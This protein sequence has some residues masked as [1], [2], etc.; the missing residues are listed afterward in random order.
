VLGSG[1]EETLRGPNGPKKDSWVWVVD[2]IDGTTNFASGLTLS[3][4]SIC[5]ALNGQ[6]AVAVVYDPFMDEMFS[7]VEGQGAT[8]NGERLSVARAPSTFFATASTEESAA[9]LGEAVVF[10]GSPPALNSMGPSLRGIAALMPKVRTVRLVGSAALMLAWVAAGRAQAYF[11]ADLNS[12]D[13]AAGALLIQEAGGAVCDLETLEPYTLRTRRILAH[14]G[15]GRLVAALHRELKAANA[16]RLDDDADNNSDNGAEDEHGR[17]DDGG[18]EGRTDYKSVL[19][20]AEIEEREDMGRA[21][22][23]DNAAAALANKKEDPEV[24]AKRA[25]LL[26]ELQEYMAMGRD[27]AVKKLERERP[28][29]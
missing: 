1:Q 16:L 20:M 25:A 6:P 26:A 29:G 4:V 15:D 7:A 9:V 28:P 23:R 18:E 3:G 27:A 13:S 12:W 14:N 10:A 8:C 17:L 2:P 5:C 22:D 21:L 19:S 24:E 11:E